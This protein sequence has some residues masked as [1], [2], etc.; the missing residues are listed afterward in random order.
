[1]FDRI[2][3]D[4]AVRRYGHSIWHYPFREQIVPRFYFAFAQIHVSLKLFSVISPCFFYVT[5]HT[6]PITPV[7]FNEGDMSKNLF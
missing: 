5:R 3:L 1:M 2:S 6:L 4:N 7:A